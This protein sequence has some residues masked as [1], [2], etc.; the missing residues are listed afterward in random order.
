MAAIVGAAILCA[1]LTSCSE[2]DAPGPDLPS[3]EA[4][5]KGE[6]VDVDEFLDALDASFD[7]GASA[8]VAFLVEGTARVRGSGV[9]AY[10]DDGMDVDVRI[11]DWQDT[12]GWIELRTVGG[13]A[14][15]RVP[16]SRGLWVD[17]SDD[18]DIA[19]TL[20]GDGDPRRQVELYRD[21]IS[22]VRFS[23]EEAVDGV[24]ARRFQM[25]AESNDPA[26]TG[27]DVTEFWFDDEGRV[28]R[29]ST[30]VTGGRASFSWLDWETAVVID[31]P[32]VD[33]VIT[34][35]QLERLRRQQAD[36]DTG[37]N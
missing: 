13:D 33:R 17:I 22:E 30:E 10:D 14:Y 31:A 27:P 36:R 26:A 12:G 37:R 6:Q 21:R 32:P 20:V 9:V 3:L 5:E 29:R 16:E 35:R 4:A 28:V 15:M 2:D 18:D 24:A 8:R 11:R 23:G 7:D 1:S 19:A 25:T 34:L